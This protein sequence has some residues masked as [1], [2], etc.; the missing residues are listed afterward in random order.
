MSSDVAP[1]RSR[2]VPSDPARSPGAREGAAGFVRPRTT[3]ADLEPV[4]PRLVR[5]G[6]AQP[7][8]RADPALTAKRLN[9]RA[10]RAA[11]SWWLVVP[12][13]GLP[14]LSFLYMG[15]RARRAQWVLA[16]VVYLLAASGATALLLGDL[17]VTTLLG[18][19]LAFGTWGTG[20]VHSTMANSTWLRIKAAFTGEPA[21]EPVPAAPA[22][23]PVPLDPVEAMQQRLKETVKLANRSGGRLPDGAVPL[24]RQIEDVLAPLLVHVGRRGA[25]AEEQHNLEAIVQEYLPGAVEH[26]LDLPEDYALNTRGPSGTTAAEELVNQLRLLAE[27]A[28]D[29]QRAVYDHDAA[30]L[31]VQGR[32]LDAKFRRSDLDL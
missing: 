12:L 28:K 17:G 1:D 24:V 22:A 23:P 8:P 6:P 29:L 32:F 9:S 31:S 20:L 10:W 16:A 4:R 7:R 19:L 21:V 27:G 18:I 30:K 5:R 2:R 11:N 13:V 15:L 26:Y 3:A 14:W 25:E